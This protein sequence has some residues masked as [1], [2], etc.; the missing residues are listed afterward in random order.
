MEQAMAR[1]HRLGQTKPVRF[2][3]L[4]RESHTGRRDHHLAGMLS[5]SL[6]LKRLCKV[7]VDRSELC[8]LPPEI[9]AYP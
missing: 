3:K 7:K 9:V 4:I 6:I 2:V 1:F 8:T 5:I